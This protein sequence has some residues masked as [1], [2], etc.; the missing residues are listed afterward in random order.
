MTQTTKQITHAHLHI[1]QLTPADN[2]AL[3]QVIRDVSAEYGLTPDKGFSVADKTLDCLSE[4][5]QPEGSQYWVIEYQGNVVGGAGVA[6]LAGNDGVCELQKMYFSHVIRGQGMAKTLSRQ[7][8]EYA[9]QQGYQSMYLETTAVLGEALALYKKL[10]FRHCQ[11]LGQTGHDA[12]E[13]AM[14]L[15]L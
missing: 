6:P 8:I 5:Y 15:D 7:C 14:I 4:V 13:I 9:K 12:C 3:A 10:G 1:R 11:H 2:A